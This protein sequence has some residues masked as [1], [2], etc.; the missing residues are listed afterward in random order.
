MANKTPKLVVIDAQ[1]YIWGIR[2]KANEDQIH[3]IQKCNNFIKWLEEIGCKIIIPAPVITEVTQL[4]TKSEREQ[5][6]SIMKESF[7]IKPFDIMASEIC[8]EMMNIHLH[9]NG[10]VREIKAAKKV[11]LTKRKVKYD[12]MIAAIAAASGCDVLY[13]HDKWLRTFCSGFVKALDI[14]AIH[15]QG[16]LSLFES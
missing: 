4:N 9:K 16:E 3:M 12:C 1:T 13:S 5:I 14:P 15:T 8:S 6:V 7:I 2:Q 10:N 11:G